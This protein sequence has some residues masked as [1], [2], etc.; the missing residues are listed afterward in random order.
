MRCHP[1]SAWTLSIPEQMLFALLRA[2]LQE[3]EVNTS[4]F[5]KAVAE[6]WKQCY[7]LACAQGVMALA[8]D[9][10]CKTTV[11]IAASASGKTVLG[12]RGGSL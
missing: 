2:S 10:L 11:I 4:S 6:D 8:W 5:S 1:M 9:G 3:T 7:R 12:N